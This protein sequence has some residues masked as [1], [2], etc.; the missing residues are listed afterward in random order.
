MQ[1][2]ATDSDRRAFLAGATA[3]AAALGL[4][5]ARRRRT[6]TVAQADAITMA[7]QMRK[8]DVTPL[9]A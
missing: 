4:P 9:E 8:G 1:D 6:R 5:A 3:T 2:K 7:A